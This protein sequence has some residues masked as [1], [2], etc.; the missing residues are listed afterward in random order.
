MRTLLLVWFCFNGILLSGQ[1]TGTQQDIAATMAAA[2]ERQKLAVQQAM[3]ASLDR[4]RASIR[5]QAGSAVQQASEGGAQFFTVP[6]PKSVTMPETATGDCAPLASEEVESLIDENA[7]REDLKPELLREVM[8]RESGFRPCAV[9]RSGA[10][11]LMQLMPATAEQFHVTDAFDPKQN[12]AA[13]ARFLKTLLTKYGGDVSLALG[14][15]NAGPTRVD[16]A[17][18]VPAIPETQ[19]YVTAILQAMLFRH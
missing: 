17:G 14:A 3:T 2:A 4:Q 15:Y 7:R 19:N 10:Q 18:G 13:G 6:W 9:S 16:N 12:A 5:T 1:A 8:R 11:G